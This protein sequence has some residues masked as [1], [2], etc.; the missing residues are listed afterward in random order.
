VILTISASELHI[1]GT[2]DFAGDRC[3]LKN[4][5]IPVASILQP[6]II[7]NNQGGILLNVRV[8]DP[9]KRGKVMTINFGDREARVVQGP[10]TLNSD[11]TLAPGRNAVPAL[12]TI[13]IALER[14]THSPQQR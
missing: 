6:E 14:A 9:E 10:R 4:A 12:T 11:H 8:R 3:P 5:S 1:D 2:Q 7:R 13:K